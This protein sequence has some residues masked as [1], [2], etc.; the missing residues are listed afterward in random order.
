MK[1]KIIKYMSIILVSLGLGVLLVI[2]L[3]KENKGTKF[4]LN[5]FSFNYI[6][7]YEVGMDLYRLYQAEDGLLFKFVGSDIFDEY[8]GYYY[9]D[10]VKELPS[11][12]KNIVLIN[13]ADIGTWD[14]DIDNNCYKISLNEY[15]VMYNKLYESDLGDFTVEEE[16]KSKIMVN[17]DS[18]CIIDYIY[19]DY[20]K[21]VDTYLVNIVRMDNKIVIYEKVVFI[22]IKEDYY[23]FYRDYEMTDLVYKLE[24]TSDV[25]V[26]FINNSEVV[27]NVLLEF[28]NEL[29]IYEY[30]YVKGVDTY[31]LESIKK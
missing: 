28:Q 17:N 23:Y 8:Y 7:D 24:N 2:V 6:V 12:L 13:E 11:F 31:Y 18:L 20:T 27:S 25:D 29:D 30:T 19:N 3:G 5:T 1:K 14:Y 16:F 26:S 21:F 10:D 4:D 15:K 22:D 9:R